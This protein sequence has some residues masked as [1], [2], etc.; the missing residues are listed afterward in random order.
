[1][2]IFNGGGSGGRLEVVTLILIGALMGLA[3]CVPFGPVNT[4]I[5][6]RTLKAGLLPGLSFG[7]GAVSFEIILAT[8]ACL[9]FGVELEDYPVLTRCLLGGGFLLLLAMGVM[10]LRG[11]HRAWKNK[12]KSKNCPAEN[13][14][15]FAELRASPAVL[16]AQLLA[17]PR[18]ALAGLV[19][20]ILSFPAWL[21]WLLSIP[22]VIQHR[23]I[24]GP[25]EVSALV[26]GIALGTV[27]WVG[28]F[29]FVI[30][31]FKRFAQDWWVIAADLIG[32]A[33]LL[34]FSGVALV[35]LVRMLRE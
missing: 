4:E 6:R 9:G 19:M 2:P 31:Y 20:T 24:Q 5:A 32:A 3:S 14:N 13:G 25:L 35:A 7:V 18:A 11:A 26:A 15:E 8:A 12:S 1:M 10:A 28:V 23:H 30:A 27:G 29:A 16:R 22:T 21:F 34:L 17:M 33:M